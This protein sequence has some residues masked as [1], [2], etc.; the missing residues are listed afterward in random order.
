M[1]TYHYCILQNDPDMK[2]PLIIEDIGHQTGKSLTNAA[3]EVVAELV[4]A[5]YLPEGRQLLYYDSDGQLDEIL[6]EGGRFA[7]FAPGPHAKQG[8]D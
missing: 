3:E 7:G 5:G 2:D 8:N 6:I 4:E 1:K